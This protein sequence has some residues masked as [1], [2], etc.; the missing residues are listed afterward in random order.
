LTIGGHG[1]GCWSTAEDAEDNEGW[2]GYGIGCYRS[3]SNDWLENTYTFVKDTLIYLAVLIPPALAIGWA[4]KNYPR[5][6]VTWRERLSLVTL[7]VLTVDFAYCVVFFRWPYFGAR[8][9]DGA[10][11]W[12]LT[13]RF[14]MFGFYGSALALLFAIICKSAKLRVTLAVL[15]LAATCFWYVMLIPITDRYAVESAREAASQSPQSH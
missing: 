15:S 4:W 11:R 10:A 13:A 7:T 6:T 5:Q 14:V 1:K 12:E 3:Q 2:L 8:V 9:G